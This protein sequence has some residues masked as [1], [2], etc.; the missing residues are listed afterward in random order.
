M[1]VRR[2]K[3]GGG[4]ARGY[5]RKRAAQAGDEPLRQQRQDQ[6]GEQGG[7]RQLRVLGLEVG[8]VDLALQPLEHQFNRQRPRN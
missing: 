3:E 2:Y 8:Q 1:R 7:A 5:C 4:R 6:R